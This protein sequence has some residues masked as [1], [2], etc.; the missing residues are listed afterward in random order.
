MDEYRTYT[1]S[2][3]GLT[4]SIGGLS[5]VRNAFYLADHNTYATIHAL[6]ESHSLK[7]DFDVYKSIYEKLT[8]EFREHKYA[9]I[10]KE[11]SDKMEKLLKGA[12]IMVDVSGED[13]KGTPFDFDNYSRYKLIYL[14][15]WASWCEPCR[16]LMPAAKIIQEKL[17][18]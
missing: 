16:E 7:Q 3:T 18:Y 15:I 6:S 4:T 9:R 12:P 11:R 13:G 2:I 5:Q 1:D 14:D 10:Y 17:F 8:P